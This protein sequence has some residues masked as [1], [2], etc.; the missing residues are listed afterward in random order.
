LTEWLTT[1]AEYYYNVTH[2]SEMQQGGHFAALEEPQALVSDIRVFVG[3]LPPST[4]AAS[5]VAGKLP[6]SPQTTADRNEL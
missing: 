2:W 6:S 1:D 3:A 5:S 4:F